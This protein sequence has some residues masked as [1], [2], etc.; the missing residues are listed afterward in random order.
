[1]QQEAETQWEQAGQHTVHV[2][3][4]FHSLHY[5]LCGLGKY[6]RRNCVSVPVATPKNLFCMSLWQRYLLLN[7]YPGI[8]LVAC[9]LWNGSAMV[10]GSVI[11]QPPTGSTMQ[12]C[13]TAGLARPRSSRDNYRHYNIRIQQELFPT[14]G[15]KEVLGFVSFFRFCAGINTE[16]EALLICCGNNWVDTQHSRASGSSHID[17]RGVVET[18]R[19]W[20]W[21]MVE[22]MGSLLK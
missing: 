4:M 9:T 3:L 8:P 22:F 11:C 18:E 10:L 12:Q 7:L 5:P 21:V 13:Q 20:W 16:I 6:C 2:T 17:Y 19:T 15:L 1:M 14:E